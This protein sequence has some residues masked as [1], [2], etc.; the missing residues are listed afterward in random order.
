MRTA[1]VAIG[2]VGTLA[3]TGCQT[4]TNAEQQYQAL[5]KQ[6]NDA[7]TAMVACLNEKE[8]ANPVAT[9]ITSEEVYIHRLNN[10]NRFAL[11]SSEKKPTKRQIDALQTYLSQVT[12]PCRQA[13]L[14]P[15]AGTSFYTTQL[16]AYAQEDRVF[17][18]FLKGRMTIGDLNT[19]L[20]Q[21]AQTNAIAQQQNQQQYVNS[22]TASHNQEIAQR[23]RQGAA[24]L[25]MWAVQQ[26]INQQNYNNQVN[27]IQPPP[28]VNVPQ[29]RS[30]CTIQGNT[31][32]CAN[33]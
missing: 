28:L 7:V 16:G 30:K 32:D 10:P 12:L 24:F 18:E 21:L 11:L 23:Q 4:M 8:A 31:A 9:K 22:L 15:L 6:R 1:L 33:Y 2:L 17:A 5:N 29:S 19:R 13:L 3:L 26:S 27:S 25:Q 20:D 14:A